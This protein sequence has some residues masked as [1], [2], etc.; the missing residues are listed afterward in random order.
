MDFLANENIPRSSTRLLEESGHDILRIAD[1][2]P[3]A[4][5]RQVLERAIEENRIILTFDRDYGE[6]IFRHKARNVNGIV[7]FRFAPTSPD[8]AGVIL[9][10]ILQEQ[11]ITLAG[12]FTVIE[13]DRIRQR[14]LDAIND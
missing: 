5:D 9:S 10:G 11:G 14:A 3:G 6:L 13:R 2:M 12:M 7:Y 4:T 1:E 8:E